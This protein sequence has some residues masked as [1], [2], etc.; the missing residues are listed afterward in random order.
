MT[1]RLRKMNLFSLITEQAS[2]LRQERM[3][4]DVQRSFDA[5]ISW[6]NPHAA[7]FSD[8]KGIIEALQR[9]IKIRVIIDKPAEEKLLL[10]T[11]KQFKKYP[12]FEIKYFLN[13]PKALIEIYDKNEAW[14]STCSTPWLKE[15]PTLRIGNPCLLLI[16][17]DYFEIM[18]L[19]ALEFK[20]EQP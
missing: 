5:I 2:V 7:I 14:V 15:C 13:A 4:G 3:I 12:S 11:I 6:R 18:W 10:D 19:T 20:P 8:V 9:G 16:L 1:K 17:H